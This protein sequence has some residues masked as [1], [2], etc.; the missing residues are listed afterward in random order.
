MMRFDEKFSDSSYIKFNDDRSIISLSE[1]NARYEGYNRSRQENIVYRVDEGI[2]KGSSSWKC[3]YAIYTCQ[4][5]N[6]YLIELKGA[7]Y[8][9]AL[10]QILST[11]STLLP[12]DISLNCVFA[13]VV[14]SKV[15]IP[16]N[17]RSEITR[18]EEKLVSELK[19][20]SSDKKSQKKYFYKKNI[21]LTEDII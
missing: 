8:S 12:P 9:H 18:Q 11:I 17:R 7:D 19:K 5:N 3:D 2:I 20:K 16:N 10:E 13:R 6:L 14:L 21:I 15:N 1:N 4:T